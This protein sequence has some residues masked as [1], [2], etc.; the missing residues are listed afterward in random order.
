MRSATTAAI[1]VVYALTGGAQPAPQPAPQITTW[2]LDNLTSLN[3]ERVS[4]IGAPAVVH[5]EIGPAVQF[6][7]QSDGLQIARNPLEGLARFTVDVLFAVDPDGPAEQ[8]FL[9]MQDRVAD[10]R[11][12]VELRMNAGRW[13]LDSYLRHGTAQLT[14]LDAAM[15]HAVSVWRVA[16]LTFD[17]RRMRHYVNGVEQGSGEVAF[18]PMGTGDTT[19]GVRQNRVS[20]FKGRIHTVRVSPSVLRPAQFLVAPTQFIPLWP[21]GV[22]GR[23]ADA[24]PERFVNGRVTNV[25]DPSVTHYAPAP[26][27]GNGTAVI[28]LA[29]GSYARIAV[30]TEAMG[31][32][33]LLSPRGVAVFVLKYRL[34][35]YGHPAPLRDVLR[36]I[37][38]IRSRAAEFDVRPDRIGL[39]GASA[40][41]HL[42]A[43]AAALF[44][45]PE[46]KTGAPIDTVSA[47]PD[48][49]AL[50]YPVVTMKAPHAHADSR[51]NLLGD[52][53]AAP[54]I[55]RLSIETQVRAGMPPFFI[56]HTSEDRSVPIEHSRLLAAALTARDV[57]VETHYYERGAHGFGFSP[58]LGAT[59]EW[60]SK[61]A[62]WLT[63]PALT[64]VEPGLQARRDA[65]VEPDLQVRRE[66]ARGIEG[67]R[68]ADLGNGTFLNPIL[69]GDHPDPS[70]LKD[71]DDYYMTFSSFDA[72]PGLVI[73]HSRD[74]V[75]WQPI[76]PTLFKNVGSVWAPELVKHRRPLLHLLPGHR[77]VSIELRDL[78]R[79]HP[80]AVERADRSQDHA[81]RSRSRRRTRRQALP[82][83]Q[84]RRAGAAGRRRAVDHRAV[85]ED[86]RR[87]EV[88]G[89][90][91]RRDLR[92]GRAEDSQARRLLLHGPRR[93]RHRRA[94]DRPHDRRGA[95]EDHRRA[96]G[97]LTA[98]PDHAHAVEA[99]SAGGRRDTARSSRIAPASGG[100]SITPTRTATTRS[101]ARR[102]SSRSSGPPTAGSAWPAPIRPR[103][104]PSRRATPA[105][106]ALR[107]RTTSRAPKM[108]VQWSFYAGDAAD[109][110]RYRYENNSAGAEG[111]RAPGPP[112]A[113][114]CG[115]STA[116]MPTRWRSRSTPTPMR[117]AGCSCST[118]ASSTPVLASPRGTCGCT[119]TAW[120]ARRR[121]RQHLGQRMW[122][123]LRN[124]RHIV[125]LD[126]SADGKTWERYDRAHR[127]VRL[128]PQ[129]RLRFPEPASGALRVAATA[130][131]ASATSSTG[132]CRSTGFSRDH[133]SRS[134]VIGSM[135]AARRA[136]R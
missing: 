96:V 112:T 15:V 119:S 126:Y 19:I 131:C 42:A 3:G 105:R 34:A 110:E 75:N 36:A 80:R 31:A 47:R 109:R 62:A 67:Q 27:T 11:A 70:I 55:N 44:D 130:R 30:D 100:W 136:G 93:G 125:T 29:G 18:L 52:T 76:G 120:I 77:A 13:A 118:A 89:R 39:F 113:R 91:G 20:W 134:A 5:T 108:G 83:P 97:E 25:H 51:R 50:L 17:G 121:S 4:M 9:H 37:R 81:H 79:Q 64:A 99:T 32:V 69:R 41:G 68:K 61:L 14:L 56:V 33:D 111:A 133:S 16:T 45:A 88:S 49:V 1:L 7:G 58:D 103:R 114:R 54:A 74:L 2:R 129:R 46:G 78:G 35:E 104:S 117:A 101:A 90:L 60:P 28:A 102:C 95:F 85:E 71:G 92:A 98:Q 8:R 66:W 23:R 72:Y 124:D 132:R 43:S 53:I 135:R 123:R 128:P 82:V 38:L 57:P 122:I 6:N 87:L 116:I 22:P 40:G 86:L 63:G 127:G 48:F 12:L 115:S 73:W 94:A 24:G 84:R 26:G 107:S 65:L 10:N 21:E 106:T 59:S